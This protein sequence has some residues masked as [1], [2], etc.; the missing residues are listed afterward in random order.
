MNRKEYG[1]LIEGWRKFL[2]ESEEL[3]ATNHEAY[4]NKV[5]DKGWGEYIDEKGYLN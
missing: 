5:I 1:L 3:P 4:K 2:N